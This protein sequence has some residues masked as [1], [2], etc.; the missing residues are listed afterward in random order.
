MYSS[1]FSKITVDTVLSADNRSSV[2][3]SLL[4]AEGLVQDTKALP[5]FSQYELF[6]ALTKAQNLN[7]SKIQKKMEA[8]CNF[9]VHD[10]KAP[11]TPL[12]SLLSRKA[13]TSPEFVSNT[14][15]FYDNALMALFAF[16]FKFRIELISECGGRL[17]T[18]I[19]GLKDSYA[20]RL[21]MTADSYVLLKKKAQKS[22]RLASPVK[23][24]TNS[25]M[26]QIELVSASCETAPSTP[27]LE[28]ASSVDTR[29][30][31]IA[32]PTES[33]SVVSSEKKDNGVRKNVGKL[34]F[35][36]EQ[37]EYGFIVMED[38]TEIFVHKGDLV[39]QKIDTR[40]LAY[41]KQ[42]Y[43]IVIEF[44]VQEYKGKGKTYR[45]AVDLAISNMATTAK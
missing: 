13:A 5:C 18:Q 35:Y 2:H 31:S 6:S 30:S 9:L 4:R 7:Q 37:K 36:N 27:K 19:F 42:F 23:T 40:Y 28:R 29:S 3:S 11:V 41:Y 15:V 32:E 22:L 33:T 8:L 38:A 20:I 17:S 24:R 45:K 25:P 16:A 12:R 10:A 34:K 1:D 14:T 44:N 26:K 39:K 43:D 21:L